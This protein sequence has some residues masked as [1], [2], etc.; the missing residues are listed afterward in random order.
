MNNCNYLGGIGAWLM[1]PPN[2]ALGLHMDTIRVA[3]GLHLGSATCICRPHTCHHCGA[4]LDSLATHGLSCRWSEGRH[5]QRWTLFPL[6]NLGLVHILMQSGATQGC[7]HENMCA[8]LRSAM[9][10]IP[11]QE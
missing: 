7:E 2:S 3:V 1:A 6:M 10:S 5:H 9:Q 8:M 11:T 4:K